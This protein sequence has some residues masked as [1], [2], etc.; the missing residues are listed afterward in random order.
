MYMRIRW[1]RSIRSR[2]E[3]ANAYEDTNV[4]DYEDQAL[5]KGVPIVA[6]CN[7]HGFGL[8][9]GGAEYEMKDVMLDFFEEPKGLIV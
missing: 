7:D 1:G 9:D 3:F 8:R 6:K 5:R 2:V 4:K